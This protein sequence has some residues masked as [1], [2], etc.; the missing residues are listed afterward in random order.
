MVILHSTGEPEQLTKCDWANDTRLIC[1]IYTRTGKG[2]DAIGFTRLVAINSDGSGLKL[3]SGKTSDDA[4]ELTQ[5]GGS[6]IDWYGDA[7][8]SAVLM[9]RQFAELGGTAAGASRPGLAVERVDPVTLKRTAV[10]TPTP[11]ARE[12]ITDGQGSVRIMGIAQEDDAGYLKGATRYVFRQRGSRNW[13]PMGLLVNNGN[14]SE[15]FDPWAVD[16]VLDVAYGFDRQDGHTAL[17]KFALDGSATKTLVY[18][19]PDVDIDGI[20]RIG[21]KKRVVGVTYAT[22]RRQTDFFDPELQKLSKSLSRALPN[23]PLVSF[24]DASADENRLLLWLGSDVD[25]GHYMV[26]DKKTRQLAPLFDTRPELFGRKL[27]QVTPVLIPAKDGAQI[28]GY[29]TL[30]PGSEGKNLPAIVMPHGGPG[31]RDE[32]G[33]D[34]L[35]QFFAARGYA[36]LQPNFRGSTG[37]GDSWFVQNGFKSWHIA[38]DDVNDAGRWLIKQGITTPDHLAIVGWSYGG[39][40]A[41]QSQVLDADLFKAIVAIA[42]VTDLNALRNEAREFKNFSIVD[43]FIGNGPHVREGSPARNI[44]AFKAPVLMFHGDGDQNVGI[45]ESR[46]MA[47]RLRAAGKSVELVE[48]KGLDHQL[49]DSDIRTQMLAKTDTFLRTTMKLPQ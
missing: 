26:F 21:R 4:I 22:D 10:E 16:P 9:T 3:A 14:V 48:F 38:I 15:G 33:F 2:V 7:E 11:H 30:P 41:L 23:L 45:S 31:A 37:Y 25:P 1:S 35:A 44:D 36:V 20:V 6:V 13:Q 12:Y 18:A 43:A 28:P 49:D 24:V 42:P 19:R 8:G 5:N 39:Y 46:L 32:W 47:S 29:L 34:W 40:A 27:A 17:F